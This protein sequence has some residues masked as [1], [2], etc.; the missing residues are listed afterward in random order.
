MCERPPLVGA[1]SYIVS[2]KRLKTLGENPRFGGRAHQ[3]R[4]YG[5]VTMRHQTTS[6]QLLNSEG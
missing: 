1:A 4:R 3:F 2:Q 5:H 6:F